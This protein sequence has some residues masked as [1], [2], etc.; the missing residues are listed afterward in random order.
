MKKP[1]FKEWTKRELKGIENDVSDLNIG[2]AYLR[3]ARVAGRLGVEYSSLGNTAKANYQYEAAADAYGEIKDTRNKNRMLSK[4][5][6]NERMGPGMSNTPR[7]VASVA[8]VFFLVGAFVFLSFQI[9]GNSILNSPGIANG[10]LGVSF[11]LLAITCFYF[12]TRT[13]K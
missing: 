10:F 1:N 6:G 5:V 2:S 12:L 8:G 11:F 3:M 7:R 4:I 9:T 13:G